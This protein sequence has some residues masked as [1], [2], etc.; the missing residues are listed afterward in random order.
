MLKM[1]ALDLR[2]VDRE[3]FLR[4][5]SRWTEDAARMSQTLGD[6]GPQEHLTVQMKAMIL[7]A[8]DHN[9]EVYECH[10]GEEM[11]GV[12]ALG[13]DFPDGIEVVAIEA[14]PTCRRPFGDSEG[15]GTAILDA[16]VQKS[17][18]KGWEGKLYAYPT[19]DAFGFFR[20]FG[21]IFDG[22]GTC[23]GSYR[24]DRR[25]LE[26]ELI[27]LT[28]WAQIQSAM[29]QWSDEPK[30]RNF[31]SQYQQIFFNDKVVPWF[32][33]AKADGA[34]QG[35]VACLLDPFHPM[36]WV[37][38]IAVNPTYRHRGIATELLRRAEQESRARGCGGYLWTNNQGRGQVFT[39]HRGFQ[40]FGYIG[41][42]EPRDCS[43][44]SL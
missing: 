19:R 25:P 16:I 8:F 2:P 27:E 21:F 10:I 3:T 11:V 12:V 43:C 24:P 18:E 38:T 32:M 5:M 4:S 42:H 31:I 13:Y 40:F 39:R 34:I 29:K 33:G 22:M 1:D 7:D 23:A 28:N 26:V 37:E 35:I 17:R 41:V 15:I 9:Q 14:A 6:G 44:C 30:L 20:K 36:F